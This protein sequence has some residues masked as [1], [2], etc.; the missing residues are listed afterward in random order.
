MRYLLIIPVTLS[1]HVSVFAQQVVE[2]MEV[3]LGAG[4]TG[5]INYTPLD[6]NVVFGLGT[7]NVGVNFTVRSG[8]VMD[9]SLG[10]QYQ[11]DQYR[12]QEVEES[13][14]TY[15]GSNGSSG[16]YSRIDTSFYTTRLH[17]VRIPLFF[18]LDKNK[19]NRIAG[20]FGVSADIPIYHQAKRTRQ[21][22][23][24]V[25]H[26]EV[27]SYWSENYDS[28]YKG[29]PIVLPTVSL[30]GAF[31]FRLTD[32]FWIHPYAR[33]IFINNWSKPYLL[34][35]NEAS[36]MNRLTMNYYN[37]YNLGMEVSWKFKGTT[38]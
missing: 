31:S 37:I 25:Y 1:L 3:V 10:L 26:D 29:N 23:T 4:T 30:T 32:H 28:Q 16:P 15:L 18:I 7:A 36:A 20:K 38:N 19:M 6:D 22:E 33:I 24:Y 17:S 9:M 14:C 13:C 8:E 34:E 5:I 27:Y 11:F 2:S 35:I 12:T 21:S